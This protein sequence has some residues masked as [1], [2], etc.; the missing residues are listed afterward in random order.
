MKVSAGSDRRKPSQLPVVRS[1]FTALGAQEFGYWLVSDR[2]CHMRWVS[3][4][5]VVLFLAVPVVA[6]EPLPSRDLTLPIFQVP[7]LE[8]MD[9][10]LI[11][12][13]ADERVPLKSRIDSEPHTIFVIKRHVGAALGYDNGIVHT[14]IG[15]YLTVAELGRWNFGIPAVEFGVGRYPVYDKV[16]KLSFAKDQPTVL[17]S[18]ASVHYRGGHL[19]SIGKDWYFTLEQIYDSRANL[20]GS[21]FGFS[22]SNP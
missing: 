4:V 21:Q 8:P 17:I 9:F 14:G 3:A 22:F 20:A 12:F 2:G 16:R 18:L 19:R 13:R 15:L 10:D 7:G 11:D 1:I 5:V 6:D